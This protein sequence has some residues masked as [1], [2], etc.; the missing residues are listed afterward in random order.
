MVGYLLVYGDLFF[1]LNLVVDYLLLHVA[2]LLAGVKTPGRRLFPAATA[3][4]FYAV[5]ILYPL[6]PMLFH[7]AIRIAFPLLVLAIAF[8]PV[9]PSTFL[10]LAGWWYAGSAFMAGLAMA[11]VAL[12]GGM[13]V[14]TWASTWL[15]LAIGATALVAAAY[16]VIIVAR[17]HFALERLLLPVEVVIGGQRVDLVGL[18]D[19]GN[20][21]RDPL[22]QS[23]VLVVE[24]RALERILPPGFSLRYGSPRGDGVIECVRMLGRLPGWATRVRVLPYATLGNRHGMMLGFRPDAVA[25]MEGRMRHEVQDATVAVYGDSLAQGAEYQALVHPSF[26]SGGSA[27]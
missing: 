6:P 5:G 8:L 15:P 4:A 3:G 26:L 17:R 20:Q 16:W 10:R 18:V 25:V 11:V 9:P 23:P 19:T 14:S 21:L 22:T 7:P 2:G 12:E 27:A 1:G 13:P 24:M